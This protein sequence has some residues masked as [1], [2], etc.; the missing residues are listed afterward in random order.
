MPANS[1]T[2]SRSKREYQNLSGVTNSRLWGL[3]NPTLRST[4]TDLATVW[5]PKRS[6]RLRLNADRRRRGSLEIQRKS[7]A[8]LRGTIETAMRVLHLL[9]GSIRIHS[10]CSMSTETSPNGRMRWEMAFRKTMKRFGTLH[11]GN[12]Q[13]SYTP[14]MHADSRSGHFTMRNRISHRAIT[15]AVASPVKRLLRDLAGVT[16]LA[17]LFTDSEWET[18]NA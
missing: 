7:L 10:D 8:D 14:T 3:R 9:V 1:A 17:L 13:S 5:Q 16:L 18:R 11:G 6:E 4:L 2:G 12:C 15:P